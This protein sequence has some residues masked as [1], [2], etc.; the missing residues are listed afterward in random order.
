MYNKYMHTQCM[1]I[2]H[3]SLTNAMERC[4]KFGEGAVENTIQITTQLI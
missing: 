2:V 3:V 4:S 1:F